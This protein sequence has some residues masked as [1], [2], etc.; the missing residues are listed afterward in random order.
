[1][2]NTSV[3]NFVGGGLVKLRVE[4]GKKKHVI[5]VCVELYKC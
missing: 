3:E 1:M 2:Q 5:L 4:S